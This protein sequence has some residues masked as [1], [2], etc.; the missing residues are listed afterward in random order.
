MLDPH[1]FRVPLHGN[2]R[3]AFGALKTLNDTVG[4][5]GRCLKS[6]ADLVDG[7]VVAGV[8]L[9]RAAKG[10]IKRGTLQK[11]HFVNRIGA[12][13]LLRMLDVG[14]GELRAKVLINRTAEGNVDELAASAD[15][16]KR[17]ARAV[18]ACT[19]PISK[20]SRL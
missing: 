20:T 15:A 7:L 6:L 8:D 1:V 3:S 19:S 12:K 18:R 2:N 16:Q 14:F 17:L 10:L 11:A 9:R 5:K 13:C 4:R